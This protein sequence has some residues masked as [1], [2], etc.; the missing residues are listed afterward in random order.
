MHNRLIAMNNFFRNSIVGVYPLEVQCE[1]QA[2]LGLDGVYLSLSQEELAQRD[3]AET[4]AT[5]HRHGLDLA[6]VYTLPDLSDPAALPPILRFFEAMPEGCDLEL[7]LHSSDPALPLSSAAG[8]DRAAEFLAPLLEIA[9]R[10]GSR[11]CLYHH[12]GVWLERTEDCVR[13]CRRIGHPCLKAVF[14]GFHW[15][16]VDGQ[17][18]AERLREAAPYLGSANMCGVSR[19][20]PIAGCR[21]E[22]LDSGEMDNFA[23]LGLLRRFGYTG[24]ICLQGYSLGGDVY[25]HLQRSVLA[26]RSLE[27]RLNRHPH[28]VE[29][30]LPPA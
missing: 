25:G 27:D 23:Y 21:I 10:H 5:V 3:P 9:E 7:G 4:A 15:Y 1:M 28:W 2:D 30:A 12:C 8:D 13:L 17:N 19:G 29:A 26:Y 20:G 16:A 22:P 24:R 14:C 6:V 11:V 18:L